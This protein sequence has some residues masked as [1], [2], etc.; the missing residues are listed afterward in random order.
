MDQEAG[1]QI[2]A[3]DKN[4]VHRICSGQDAGATSVEITL[5]EYGTAAIEVAD[6]GTGLKPEDYEGITTKYATSKLKNFSDLTSVTSF[7]FRQGVKQ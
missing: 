7:G 1:G 2:K 6:N 3:I 5:K 4:T